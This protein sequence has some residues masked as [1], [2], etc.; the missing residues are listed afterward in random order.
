MCSCTC[1]NTVIDIYIINIHDSY[2]TF[3]VK[4]GRHTEAIFF[5]RLAWNFKEMSCLP[6]VICII[7]GPGDKSKT[8][9]IG[10]LLPSTSYAFTVKAE[11]DAGMSTEYGLNIQTPAKRKFSITVKQ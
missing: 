9:L 7:S 8:V 3:L 11:S 5:F 6:N 10:D 2:H 4:R 1:L